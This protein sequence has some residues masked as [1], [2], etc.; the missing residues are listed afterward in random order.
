MALLL[1]A[2]A[3]IGTFLFDAL[4]AIAVAIGV[5]LANEL[6]SRLVKLFGKDRIASAGGVYAS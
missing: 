5:S 2:L 1:S 4:A 3:G 6:L